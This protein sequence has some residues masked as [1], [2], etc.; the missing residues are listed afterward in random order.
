MALTV[1]NECNKAALDGITALLAGGDFRLA[2][3]ADAEL[4]VLPFQASGGAFGAA[5]TASPAVATSTT[6]GSDTSPTPGT[7]V[8]FQLRTSTASNR[9]SGT[10]GTSGADLI[11]ASV[12][13]PSDATEVSCSNLQLS[14][15]IT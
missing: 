1:A 2:A 9:I 10:V 7:I 5:T 15:T 11:L 6:I 14:L 8:A 4:A 13:I 3:T 12:N